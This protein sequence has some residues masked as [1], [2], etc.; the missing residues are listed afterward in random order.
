MASL[1]E[2][3]PTGPVYIGLG[4]PRHPSRRPH[5]RWTAFNARHGNRFRFVYTPKHASWLNQ[6]EIWFSILQR[7]VIRY[8][9]FIDVNDLARKLITF[10]R[11]WN[12]DEAH[13]FHWTF[14]G[15]FR[16]D[17]PNSWPSSAPRIRTQ[18][19]LAASFANA[20]G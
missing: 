15:K 7:R 1:A 14:R 16:Q 13:P 3:Y 18:P 11:R 2:R 17:Q 9:N 8:G 19:K 10:I 4:Q 20:A 6:I 5:K 12:R